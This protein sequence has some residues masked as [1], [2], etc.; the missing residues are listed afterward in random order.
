MKNIR[1]KSIALVAGLAIT[2]IVGAS[3]ASLGGINGEDLGAGVDAV[4]SCDTDGVTV[5]YATSVASGVVEVDSVTISAIADACKS[6]A[7]DVTLLDAAAGD[8]LANGTLTG[9]MSGTASGSDTMSI[10]LTV[11]GSVDA[12][13][14]EGIAIV[15]SGVPTP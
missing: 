5:A 7:V 13:D 1:K 3:A 2:G 14:V 9:T 15:I 12:E 6:A 8:A 4:S 10:T 11:T